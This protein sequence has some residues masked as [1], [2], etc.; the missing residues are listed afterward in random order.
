MD[1]SPTSVN[2]EHPVRVAQRIQQRVEELG[3][4][5]SI[6]VGT[7]KTVAKIASD[8]DKPR[9]LTVVY[10]GG[11]R[12]FLAPLPVRTMSGIGA[13]AE[14]KLHSRGIRTLG[15][16]ADADEGMLLRA[17]G[18]N[19]RVMHVRANGGDDAP[20]E[21]DDTV[22]SVSNEMTF[23]VDLTTR[24]DVEGAIATIA[25][26]VGRRLRRKG[27]R[28]RTLGLRMRYDD[29]SVRSVQRQLP[30]P[31]DDE[32]SYT[33]LLYR[34]ADELWRPGM[35]VRLIGVA[36]TGFG[37]GESVQGS[38]FNIAEAAPSD[39]DVDPVI[40]DEAKRRGLI[41]ATDLVKDKFGESAVRFGRELR[42]EGNTTGSASKNPADYK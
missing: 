39:D 18:K 1:V 23:A 2:R 24:E 22:K 15:Q 21:Q 12:D 17:F 38:L 42:G 16:L 9:G 25:A 6:G 11:E 36:M 35:P 3:V 40:K 14:E 4:T 19:G 33:P 8:M 7:S 26:K 13:A 28:G 5:C 34:M 37:G 41:E 32:L 29:R 10:P 30:A 20:V 31:S 27:L